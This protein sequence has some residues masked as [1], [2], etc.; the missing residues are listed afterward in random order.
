MSRTKNV[1]E[2]AVFEP[3]R[4][5]LLDAA[6][7]FSNEAHPL[8][9][10]LASLVDDVE[11]ASA[12]PLEIFPVCHHSPAAAV[13]CIQR[14]AREAPRVIFMEMCEDL[15]PILDKLR[16]CKLPVALQAFAGH[17][18]SFPKSW[19]PLSVVA[20]LTEFSAEY[21][22]MV[23]ALENPDT[24]LVFVDRSVDHIFQW[25]PQAE[26]E[27]ERRLIAFTSSC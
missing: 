23:F 26:D 9:E 10:L 4:Q 24:E 14:L 15:R 3:L 17:T 5:Q 8:G 16:D 21:Q 11:R 18:D 2:V 6:R 19:S 22:A 7:A 27:L 25:M 12:E 20:P 1:S 13:H